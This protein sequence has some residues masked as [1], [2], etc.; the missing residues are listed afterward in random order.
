MSNVAPAPVCVRVDIDGIL[1]R[2]KV[3]RCLLRLGISQ[4]VPTATPDWFIMD[5]RCVESLDEIPRHAI[6]ICTGQRVADV[7]LAEVE[8]KGGCLIA[9]ADLSAERLLSAMF[10]TTQSP[11]ATALRDHLAS[12]LDHALATRIVQVFVRDAHLPFN[13]NH[14]IAQMG[15]S[16]TDFGTAVREI[17]LQRGEHLW[18]FLRYETLRWLRGKGITRFAAERFLG[19]VDR[20]NFRR[21]CKRAGIGG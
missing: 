2:R 12:L 9:A 16:N 15:V 11:L 5:S 6:V 20:T 1:L 3:E 14:L 21:S 13:K 19:I 7:A 18:T 8:Q 4:S 17:G 10:S